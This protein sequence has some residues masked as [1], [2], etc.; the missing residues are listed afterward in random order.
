MSTSNFITHIH[1]KSANV[2]SAQPHRCHS[3]VLFSRARAPRFPTHSQMLANIVCSVTLST[4]GFGYFIRLSSWIEMRQCLY[5]RSL[6]L[7]IGRSL[8]RSRPLSR[9]VNN[10]TCTR[11]ALVAGRLTTCVHKSCFAHT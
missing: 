5:F 1:V 4:N 8:S 2:L 11:T 7:W 10:N 9:C 3:H 6:C